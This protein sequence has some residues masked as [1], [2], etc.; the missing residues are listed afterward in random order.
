MVNIRKYTPEEAK[1]RNR[2]RNRDYQRKLLAERAG[3]T[4]EEW[5]ARQGEGRVARARRKAR[6]ARMEKLMK[7]IEESRK[8]PMLQTRPQYDTFQ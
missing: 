2:R 7:N 3:L 6:E 8:S 1:E 4:L 5:F